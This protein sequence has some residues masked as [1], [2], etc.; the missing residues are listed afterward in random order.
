M[1]EVANHDIAAADLPT[2]VESDDDV[3]KIN[4]WVTTGR[5]IA[6]KAEAERVEAKAPLL[7]RGKKL[8]GFFKGLGDLLL[9]RAKSVEQ[10]N[11]PYLS[12]KRAREAAEREA[13]AAEA[14]RVQAE[15]DRIA[16]EALEAEQEARRIA[17]EAEQKI[18]EAQG[19]EARRVA[20]QQA[21]E[22]AQTAQALKKE[23][24]AA[25]KDSIKAD[26]AADRAER[27]ADPERQRSLERTSAGGG[28]AK[29]KMV[30]KYRIE[31]KDAVQASLGVWRGLI[32]SGAVY[33]ALG[34]GAQL[35]TW[36][37]IPGVVFYE[38]EEVLTTATRS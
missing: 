18:R 19:A 27:Q 36:P 5:A 23:A 16:R 31:D 12:A 15:K 17:A 28:S 2:T 25:V 21:R 7:E 13:A 37:S 11:A 33:E 10:R 34:R 8:D 3:A 14:R 38:E 9:D 4:A 6:R 26:N 29:L 24:G 30:R 22:A 1:T 32:A 20:E 35:E